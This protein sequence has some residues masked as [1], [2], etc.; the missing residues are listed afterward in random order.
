MKKNLSLLTGALIYGSSAACSHGQD[1]LDLVDGQCAG[2]IYFSTNS[3]DFL[4]VTDFFQTD[5]GLFAAAADGMNMFTFAPVPNV[6]APFSSATKLTPTRDSVGITHVKISHRGEL[7]LMPFQVYYQN[8]GL[9]CVSRVPF[10]PVKAGNLSGVTV[11]VTLSMN[12][13]ILLEDDLPGVGSE[14]TTYSKATIDLEAPEF[15]DTEF[16][17][18]IQ[19]DRD[20]SANPV[21][22]G[23]FAG[24]AKAVPNGAGFQVSARFDVTLDLLPGEQVYLDA[25][26]SATLASDN[27]GVGPP[28]RWSAS[29]PEPITYTISSSDRAVRFELFPENPQSESERPKIVEWQQLSKNRDET[30]FQ[31][32]WTSKPERDYRIESS[33]DMKN[34]WTPLPNKDGIASQGYLTTSQVVINTQNHPSQ[35]LRI[36]LSPSP[37]TP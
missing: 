31:L 16:E 18:G 9:D 33:V 27:F 11:P 15:F 5:T 30:T 19:F 22:S 32:T 1:C 4:N 20:T 14:G 17:G 3:P 6:V 8:A 37:R 34:P 7:S 28:E 36:A 35:L 13:N 25:R 23:D 12:F 24:I 21:F 2:C 26:S 10:T 29:T